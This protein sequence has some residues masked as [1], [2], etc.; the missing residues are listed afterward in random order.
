MISKEGTKQTILGRIVYSEIP[1]TSFAIRWSLSS[2]SMY[3]V[4]QF[5]FNRFI[6]RFQSQ[7]VH[8]SV[9]LSWR[10]L[11][12]ISRRRYTSVLRPAEIQLDIGRDAEV[13]YWGAKVRGEEV[14]AY[15]DLLFREALEDGG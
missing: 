1:P 12:S 7:P 4:R 13:E 2:S 3:S 9:F 5:R 6:P 15:Y 10:A 8:R 11:A 14:V